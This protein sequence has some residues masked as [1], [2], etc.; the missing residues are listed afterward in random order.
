MNSYYGMGIAAEARTHSSLTKPNTAASS[1]VSSRA[2][3]IGGQCRIARGRRHGRAPSAWA[4]RVAGIAVGPTAVGSLRAD[5]RRHGVPRLQS[6]PDRSC[7]RA[8]APPSRA[9]ARPWG[10]TSATV[11][12]GEAG[13]GKTRLITT[14]ADHARSDGAVVLM[15][16]CI[17]LG[18]GALPYAPVVEALRGFV[19]RATPDE[20]EAWSV[21]VAPSLHVSC[22]TSVRWQRAPDPGSSIGSA[23]GRLFE[24]L[25]GVLERLAATAPVVFIVEDLHWSDQS[26]RDLLGFLVRNLH[27][28]RSRSCSPIARTSSTGAIRCCPSWPSW[29]GPAASSGSSCRPSTAGNRPSSCEAIAGHDLDAGL[30]ESIHADP[31]ATPSSRRSCSSRRATTAGASCRRTCATCCW[32]ASPASPSRPRSSCASPR[33]RAS[34]WTPRSSPRRSPWTRG[35]L[36]RAPRERRPS[37]A[38]ARPDGRHRTL[39]V[40][41]RP[42]PGGD[43]RRPAARRADAAAFGLRPDPGGHRH[44]RHRMRPSWRTTGTRPTTCR[45]RSR[46]PCARAPRRRPRYAFPEAVA[47]YERAVDLWDQVPDAEARAGRDLIDLLATLAGVARFHEP[48]RAVSHIQA[49]IGLVD[50]D[51][52]PVRAGLLYER[53]GRYSWIAGQGDRRQDAYQTAMALIPHEPPRRPAHERWPGSPR[54]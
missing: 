32:A 33:R 48:A 2:T 15:G 12:A 47:Q 50:E 29:N 42:A 49:A 46:R 18:D 23:Q 43:L 24:L 7:E 53:L 5:N 40:P 30:L 27:D 37:G 21:T 34:A 35:A 22:P 10:P 4:T 54:S 28:V 14:Y 44:A 13:V 9:G 16:G 8:R 25:L 17:P 45:G 6:R 20:L 36:R 31:G 39:R 41:S 26:T 38:G 52:E 19:R 1:A 3:T 51:A 11:I